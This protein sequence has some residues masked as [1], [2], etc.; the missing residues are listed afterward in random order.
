MGVELK[1]CISKYNSD[2][3]IERK[4]VNKT[5]INVALTI[6]RLLPK[7]ETF[8]SVINLSKLSNHML[9][10]LWLEIIYPFPN[11]KRPHRWSLRM[12]ESFHPTLYDIY[13]Y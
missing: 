9:S 12:D 2:R 3:N 13:N 4:S 6:K 5:N 7:W 10:I 11:F 8:N 1:T